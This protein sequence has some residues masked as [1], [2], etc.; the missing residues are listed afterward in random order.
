M[1]AACGMPAVDVP[2]ITSASGAISR[3]T[4]AKSR[5]ISF[6][7]STFPMICLL[8]QYIGEMMPLAHVNGSSGLTCTAPI[9]SNAFATLSLLNRD[10]LPYRLDPVVF[11]HRIRVLRN[12]T[13]DDDVIRFLI[14]CIGGCHDPHLII[15]GILFQTDTRRDRQEF[16][17]D[18]LMD[19]LRLERG[20]HHAVEARTLCELR[21]VDDAFRE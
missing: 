14:P 3:I 10:A 13:P 5:T 7:T 11:F 20:C 21:I 8:S 19:D 15:L 1:K 9:S 4:S 16:R 12:R 17:P 18:F 6:L 2:A